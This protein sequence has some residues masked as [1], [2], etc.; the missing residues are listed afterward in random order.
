MAPIFLAAGDTAT[1]LVV[2]LAG[3]M[4][5]ALLW[6]VTAYQAALPG[7]NLVT[8]G[9]A[10]AGS[11]GGVITGLAVCTVLTLQVGLMTRAVSEM[12][13]TAIYPH[14]PQTFVTASLMLC[15]LYSAYGGLERWS[16][17]TGPFCRSWRSAF[18]CWH[19]ASLAGGSSAI[20][21]PWPAPASLHCWSGLPA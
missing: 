1:W 21:C 4:A 5:L 18:C 13:S 9:R 10:A 19:S 20:C 11:T 8:L 2:L 7:G 6:P 16:A 17:S 12:A 14:T 15:A 3:I